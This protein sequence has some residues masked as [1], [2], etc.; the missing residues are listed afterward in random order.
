MSRTAPAPPPPDAKAAGTYTIKHLAEVLNISTRT[1]WRLADA[2]V[3]PGRL[4]GLGR[5]ARWNRRLVDEWLESRS[6]P[7]QETHPGHAR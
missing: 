4:S 1:A 3:I 6:G 5:I 7:G 2:G